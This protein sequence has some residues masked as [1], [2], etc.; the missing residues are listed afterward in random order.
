[1]VRAE[2]EIASGAYDCA[3]E[4]SSDIKRQLKQLGI[5]AGTLRRVAVSS[6][7]MEMNIII[8]SLGGVINLTVDNEWITLFS[9]DRGPGIPDVELAMREGFSTAGED[10][11]NMGFGA[12]MGLPNMKRNADTFNI[13]S[14]MEEGTRITITFRV[15]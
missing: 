13:F 2:Y 4:V 11:R 1:M 6:Y 9:K 15:I 7:E 10:A 3:G 8:H 12:G 14:Q 5:D